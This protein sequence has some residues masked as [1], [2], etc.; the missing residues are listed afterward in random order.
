MFATEGE[1]QELEEDAAQAAVVL[2]DAT[3]TLGVGRLEA[4]LFLGF[5]LLVTALFV[6]GVLAGATAGAGPA[7]SRVTRCPTGN[8][9]RCSPPPSSM[10]TGSVSCSTSSA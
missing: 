5:C 1:A 7:P 6:A 4:V 3:V 8:G 2:A 10:P 9:G